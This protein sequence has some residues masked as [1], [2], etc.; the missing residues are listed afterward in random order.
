MIFKHSYGYVNFVFQYGST[1]LQ[2]S[3]GFRRKG[4]GADFEQNAS[5]DIQIALHCN[6]KFFRNPRVQ[7]LNRRNCNSQ[8]SV[9]QK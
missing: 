9:K 1:W 5:A 6:L 2:L 8:F 3:S 7:Y 4:N